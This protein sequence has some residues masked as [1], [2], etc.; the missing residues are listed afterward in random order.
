MPVVVFSIEVNG[1]DITSKVASR[2]LDMVV[3]DGIGLK[4]DTLQLTL[5]DKDGQ[6][7]SPKTGAKI[8]AKGGYQDK[9]RDFGEFVVD[10]VEYEGWPQRI[11]IS[12]QSVD[13][14][15]NA[16]ERKPKG[17][18]KKTHSNYGKIFEEVAK[19]LKLS[20]SMFSDLKSLV[21][22]GEFQAEENGLE[23]LS[24]IAEKI[25]ASVSV[26]SGRLVVVP[27]GKGK[28]S[29]GKELGGIAVA[30]G[31][32]LISYST[33]HKDSSRYK[34]VEAS[35]YDRKKNERVP[36]IWDTGMEGPKYTLR[37][38][39]ADEEEAKKA[40]KAKA[41]DL[42]RAQA[43]ATFTIDG[44]PYAL[45]ESVVTVSGVRPGVD[46]KW[47]ATSVVH[48]FSATSPYTTELQCEVPTE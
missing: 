27:S 28:S 13:A 30:P 18:P 34:Q 42:V 47:R 36:I 7:Q 25:G 8:R 3:T 38:P 45:A 9:Q 11:S 5:D 2:L 15:G 48:N 16:K 20:L 32:N 35:Y 17:F 41:D 46:G 19:D 1:Q 6:I 23:F 33:S 37:S 22:P 26:K 31:L 12:A 39:F 14:K 29:S 43:T 10:N 21:S 4:S 24:R 40:A 44:D